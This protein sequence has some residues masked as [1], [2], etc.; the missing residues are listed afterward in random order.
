[1]GPLSKICKAFATASRV[2]IK[3]TQ[4]LGCNEYLCVYLQFE[5]EDLSYVSFVIELNFRPIK[6]NL[7][8]YRIYN[9]RDGVSKL[10]QFRHLNN[11]RR[12]P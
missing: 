3:D 11:G 12:P 5:F 8:P 4:S 1:M 9:A 2:H 10:G 7:S 6:L